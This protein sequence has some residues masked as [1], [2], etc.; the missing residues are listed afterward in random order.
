MIVLLGLIDVLTVFLTLSAY[1]TGYFTQPA[2]LLLLLLGLKGA[3]TLFT[4]KKLDPLGLLDLIAGVTGYLL[5]T[6]GLWHNFALV[7]LTLTGFKGLSS[8]IRF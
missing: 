7:C 6:Q 3:W 1:Y 4:I 2:I 5:L 8:I